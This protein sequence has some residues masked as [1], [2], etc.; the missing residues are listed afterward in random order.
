MTVT[1]FIT[2]L[3][4]GSIISSL[5]T[6]AIKKAYQNAQ[7]ECSPNIIALI[8]SI[9][10][11]GLGTAGIYMLMGIEWTVNNIICLVGMIVVTWICSMVGYDKVIQS[12][13][14]IINKDEND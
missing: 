4:G 9:V 7:K 13:N 14:Q 12:I 1:L 3:T 8:D 2:I 10:I 6:E 11:G 5:L